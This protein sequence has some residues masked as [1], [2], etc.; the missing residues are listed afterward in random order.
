[1]FI[2]INIYNYYEKS[3]TSPNSALMNINQITFGLQYIQPRSGFG[4]IN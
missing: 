2:T 3:N 1:M 4:Y